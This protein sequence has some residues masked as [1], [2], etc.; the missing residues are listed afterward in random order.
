[1]AYV[2][3]VMDRDSITGAFLN[4]DDTGLTTNVFLTEPRLYGIRVTKAWKGGPLLGSFGQLHEG[5]YPF[6]VELGGQV[7]HSDAPFDHLAPAFVSLFS[8][9]IDP[10][11]VQDSDLDT[12]D[13][14]SARL[15][16]RPEG[17]PWKISAAVRY[18]RTNTDVN[19][20]HHEEVAGPTVCIWPAAYRGGIFANRS[21]DPTYVIPGYEQ[22]GPGYAYSP[23]A[24][25]RPI[26]WTDSS[27]RRHEEHMIADFAV[28][29]DAG[30][31]MF[32]DRSSV[33]L[34][35]RYAKIDSTAHAWMNGVTNW[36]I[37]DGFFF[38]EASFSGD[39]ADLQAQ[40]GFKGAG[41]M[42]SWEAAQRVFG[43]DSAHAD[44]EWSLS[45]GVL[46]GKQKTT[47]DGPV[48]AGDWHGYY[49]GGGPRNLTLSVDENL[50][51]R[52]SRSV[53]VP[54]VDASLGLSYQI[55]R[56]K[57]GAGYRW[58]RYFNALDAGFMQ[59]KDYDRTIDGPYF[60]VSMGF[61]G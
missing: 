40:R 21:C 27:S 14:R 24:L 25:A 48:Q 37:P 57:L 38:Y 1:M 50:A 23:N 52:R 55:D 32:N 2:K 61:G 18:G 49:Y 10:V 15:T 5:P 34:G 44:M 8:S 39:V 54:V 12:G 59:A 20:R 6:T 33:S 35:R 11:A 22:Y 41:P 46:F 30:I 36:Q 28:G 31:G 9:A 3:N 45:G 47:I 17:S 7:Q 13:A 51:V 58:E 26:N 53:T 4:S 29:R 42:V 43:D 19:R 60:T 56:V 16:W